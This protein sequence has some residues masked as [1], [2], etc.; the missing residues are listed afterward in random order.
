M[1]YTPYY[2]GGWQSGEEGD[3]PITPAALNHIDEGIAGCLE[4]DGPSDLRATKLSVSQVNDI[5]SLRGTV[6]NSYNTARNGDDIS[7]NF[8]NAGITVYDHTTGANVWATGPMVTIADA[9]TVPSSIGTTSRNVFTRWGNVVTVALWITLASG[10]SASGTTIAT[11]PTDYRPTETR[12]FGGYVTS[13]NAVEMFSI[14]TSGQI[15]TA[16]G[17]AT[18]TGAVRIFATYTI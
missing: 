16:T 9:A 2:S 6:D 5:Y 14:N 17:S 13:A 15:Q 1:A 3:T 10:I 12:Y 18:Y 4:N 11:V 7:V 8:Q